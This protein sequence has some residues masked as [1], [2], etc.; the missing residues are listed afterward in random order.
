MNHLI[1]RYKHLLNLRD[2]KFS[3]IEHEDAMVAI[4]YRVTEA[5]GKEYILKICSRLGDYRREAYFL[6]SLEG[7]IPLP[8]IIQLVEPTEDIHGAIL[9]EC[10]PGNLLNIAD[11]DEKLAYEIGSILAKIHS[12]KSHGYGDL[13]YPE[14]LSA[15]PCISFTLKFEEGLDECKDHLPTKVI[16]KCRTIFDRLI[17]LLAGAD[18]PCVVHRDFR[19]GNLM[20]FNHQIQ[21][22]I[23]WSSGRGGFAEEDFGPIELGEWSQNQAHREALLTGYASIRPVPNYRELM[24]LLILSKAIGVI[25]FTVKRDTWK[26]RDSKIYSHYRRLLEDLLNY[27]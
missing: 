22:V 2:P 18:G 21:G 8:R 15:D 11:I 20:V 13:I 4:V 27:L 17:D 14:Q 3:L 25:G 12:I 19:P 24:P 10:L 16:D 7:K 23:D 6:K 9:M 1:P 26:A 5:S